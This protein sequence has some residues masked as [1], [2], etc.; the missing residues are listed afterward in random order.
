VAGRLRARPARSRVQ[1]VFPPSR[2]HASVAVM[3]GLV[4][5]TA[6][7]LGL[8]SFTAFLVLALAF[9]GAGLAQIL[10][11]LE[12]VLAVDVSLSMD[13]DEQRL[14]RD[15]YITAF[16]DGEVHMAITSGPH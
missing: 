16:R 15:G 10:V 8:Y 9:A 1:L 3:R 2:R 4:C 5:A 13:L 6:L 12:L 7:K 14:Q 11:D